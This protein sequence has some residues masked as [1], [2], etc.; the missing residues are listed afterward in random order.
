VFLDG[1]TGTGKTLI[2]ELIRLDQGVR[3]LYV[4]S[5]KSLQDQFAR[6]FP[7]AKVLKG[8][9][10]YP[11]ESNPNATAADCV[12]NRASDP[13]FHCEHGHAKC[14]YQIAKRAALGADLAVT[15][16]SYLLTEA[17]YVGNFSGLDMVIVDEADTLESQL[18]NFVEFRVAKRYMEMVRM[19]PPKKG[20]RKTTIIRWLEDFHEAFEPMVKSERDLRA[21][22]NMKGV[23]QATKRVTD[24]LRKELRMRED[25]EAA[26]EDTGLWL[27]QYDRDDTFIMKPVKVS[28][29]GAKYLWRHAKKWLIMSATLISSDEMADSLGLPW[30]YDTVMVPSTFPVEN[31]PIYMTPIADMTYKNMKEGDAVQDALYG[32][33]SI[34]MKYPKDRVLIHTVS[35]DLNEQIRYALTRGQYDV[36]DRGR[37][38]YSYANSRERHD[39][40]EGFKQSRVLSCWHRPWS[41][42]S[43]YQMTCAGYRSSPRFP[44]QV[45][46]IGR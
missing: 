9:A 5:D 15:N 20:A 18:M 46:Q 38:V 19:E 25:P 36:T 41:E 3:A 2:A 1:P 29:M 8:R 14:P 26:D 22:R 44:T 10:N 17:N 11:T 30:D 23:L 13:C 34:L 43:T 39:A 33:H 32:I 28:S 35:Y 16:I 45:L 6:D 7:Y 12:A 27:R 40:L 42:A 31:R 37:R 21:Q 24:E 4:C